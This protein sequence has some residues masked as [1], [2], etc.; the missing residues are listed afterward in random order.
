MIG[1]FRSKALKRL[2][3]KAQEKGIKGD[4]L[5]RVKAILSMLAAAD[6]LKDLNVPGF[7]LH[8]LPGRK[9]VRH[10]MRIT[11]NWRIT[12]EWSEGAAD[13]IDYEDYH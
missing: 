1:T 3:D 10:S 6:A 5:G 9:P 8:S 2:W 4:H 12:F 7:Y 13:K 11:G